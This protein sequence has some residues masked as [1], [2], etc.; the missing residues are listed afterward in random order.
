MKQKNFWNDAAQAGVMIALA[1]IVFETVGFYTQHVLLSLLSFAIFLLLLSFAAKRRVAQAGDT[2]YTYGQCLGFMV[3]TML[4]AGFIEGAFMSVAAN[5]LFVEKYDAMTAQV[6]ATLESTG[7]YTRDMMSQV[8]K[9]LHSPIVLILSS[10]IGSAI[11]GGFFGLFIAAFV[12]SE[13]DIFADSD[14]RDE[15]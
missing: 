12:K 3:C 14:K 13:P 1:A 10:M 15:Q 6:F 9:A 11:K 4:C 8:I 2:G 5:W 7:L